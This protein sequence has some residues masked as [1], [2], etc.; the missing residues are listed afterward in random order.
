M[1]NVTVSVTDRGGN[2]ATRDVTVKVTTWTSLE[3]YTVSNLHPQV[4]TRIT[5]TVTDPDIPITNI[6]WTWRVGGDAN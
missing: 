1:Y 2:T 6:M 5:A 4:G 3:P